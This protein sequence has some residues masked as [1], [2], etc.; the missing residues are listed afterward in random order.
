[1]IEDTKDNK[2]MNIKMEYEYVRIPKLDMYVKREMNIW[3][4][5]IFLSDV[6][7]P[8]SRSI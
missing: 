1:M 6:G 4:L 3:T 5:F 8:E 7:Q 2:P